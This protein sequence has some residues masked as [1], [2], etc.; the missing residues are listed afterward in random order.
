[1][2][3]PHQP[4]NGPVPE[5]RSA[6]IAVPI[7]RMG[8]HRWIGPARVGWCLLAAVC[9]ALF[10]A[11]VPYRYTYLRLVTPT[12]AV[13]SEQL[14]PQ[15][16]AALVG[17]G[18]SPTF[19]AAYVVALECVLVLASMAVAALIFWRK[20]DEPMAVYVSIML[21]LP[22]LFLTP[23]VGALVERYPIW[24]TPVFVLRVLFWLTIGNFFYLFPNGRFVPWW[25]RWLS[26]A[27]ATYHGCSLLVP[28]IAPPPSLVTAPTLRE[29]LLNLSLLGWLATGVLAQFVRYRQ[30]SNPLERQQT[31]WIVW[32]Y[33]VASLLVVS[34]IVVPLVIFPVLRE[35]GVPQMVH[36]LAGITTLIVA[37]S[38]LPLT[39]AFSILRY[40]LWALDLLINRTLV[41]GTLTV[42]LGLVYTGSVVLLQQLFRRVLG[43]EQDIA[44]VASTLAIAA[45]FQPFRRQIQAGIDRRFY[46]HKYDAAKTLQSFSTQVRDDVDLNRLTDDL[47]AVVSDTMQPTHVSLWLASG[48]TGQQTHEG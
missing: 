25:T 10:V 16:A 2:R 19:Y 35:P 41:Y 34:A 28:A 44:I 21:L 22:G 42:A 46:H 30:T 11:A 32:G 23:L 14:R 47:L 6:G 20:S 5:P 48:S 13:A 12:A 45:L 29:L 26:F 17:L 40:H 18:L 24:G 39:I 9:I 36:R 3:Q 1:M 8:S 4:H 7:A 15:D 33:A 37:G 27:W 43:Q 31:K 38:L